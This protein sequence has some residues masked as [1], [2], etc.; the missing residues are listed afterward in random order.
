VAGVRLV[1]LGDGAERGVRVLEFRTGT[2]F[3]FDV[4]V[5][6]AFDIGRCEING[7]A[8]GWQSGVGYKGPWFAEQTDLGWLR[9]WGGG[10]L[11]TCGLDHALFF[12]EDT[13]GQYHYAP[14]ERERFGLHGRISNTPARLVGYG[15]RWDGDD[16]VL[17]ADGEVLQASMFGEHLVLRRRIEARVGDSRLTI[18]DQVENIGWDPT[19]HMYLYHINIGF[20]VL[21]EGAQIIVPTRS[22]TA[23]GD[24]SADGYRTIDGPEPRHFE[25]VFEHDPIAEVD[26]RVPVALINRERQ[27]GAYEVFNLNQLPFHFVW[28]MLGEGSYVVGIEPSTNRTGGRLDARERGELIVLEPGDSRQYDLELGALVGG[29]QINSFVDRVNALGGV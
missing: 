13:A 2:G 29:D 20:P 19:P 28:R 9:T 26:G 8:L 4:I 17:Y 1:T 14:K 15:H 7:I 6:R 24:Y 10:L 21:D 23:R 22:V 18:H 3:V 12:A 16:C 5:D 11:T 25:R 27:I